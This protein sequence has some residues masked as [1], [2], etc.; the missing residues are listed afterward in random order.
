[1]AVPGPV[2]LPR[3][4]SID[5][6]TLTPSYLSHS[7]RF[8]F[9]PGVSD[10]VYHCRGTA[11]AEGQ[12]LFARSRDLLEMQVATPRQARVHLA[13]QALSPASQCL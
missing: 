1:M 12:D 3:L 10:A 7:E 6:S 11:L 8:D 13:K 4:P 5:F 9:R 2:R